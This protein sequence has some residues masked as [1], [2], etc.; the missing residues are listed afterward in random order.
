MKCILNDFKMKLCVEIERSTE[1]KKH[2]KPV[3]M[4]CDCRM[5]K[6]MLSSNVRCNS[7]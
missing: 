1:Q 6:A 4:E 5:S 3:V 2:G 7:K